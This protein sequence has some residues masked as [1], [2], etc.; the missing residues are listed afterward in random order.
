[1]TTRDRLL[2]AFED[3]LIEEGERTATLE[4]VAA[5]AGVSK[6]GL[7][8]HFAS[9]DALVDG[10]LDRLADLARVDTEAMSAD[11]RGPAAYY[12]DSSV[13]T[14]SPLDRALIATARLAQ[15]A[16]DARRAMRQIHGAW[17][18][19]ILQQVQDRGVARAIVLLGDGLYY[20]AV[21]GSGTSIVEA[22]HD[23][24]EL[25]QVVARLTATEA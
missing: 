6:G 14:G 24:A 10:L 20:N 12:V 4:A 18:D 5:R 23:R 22:E 9:K 15:E 17:F 3:L 8:Y 21:L 7:L 2:D 19:L 13:Y 16:E 25:L 11:P 1:M